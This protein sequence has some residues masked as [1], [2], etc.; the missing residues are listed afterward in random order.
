MTSD[1]RQ[2]KK[3]G[4]STLGWVKT[5]RTM[6]TIWGGDGGTQISD[7]SK[8]LSTLKKNSKTEEAFHRQL[9]NTF[10]YWNIHKKK[11]DS[12]SLSPLFLLFFSYYTGYDKRVTNFL[13]LKTQTLAGDVIKSMS[14]DT[15]AIRSCVR[16]PI[17][18]GLA[19]EL[20]WRS[21]FQNV[22]HLLFQGF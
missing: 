5:A 12:S 15:S 14:A 1:R 10:K 8:F 11:R 3:K 20:R 9:P 6:K 13:Y 18:G 4:F 7:L 16:E 21:N 19:R 17:V 22:S 2:K